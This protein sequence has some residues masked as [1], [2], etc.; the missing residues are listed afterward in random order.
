MINYQ[1]KVVMGMASQWHFLEIPKVEVSKFTNSNFQN[2]ENENS[3]NVFK[4]YLIG[5]I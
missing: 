1:G 4:V 2:F 5:T 3:F